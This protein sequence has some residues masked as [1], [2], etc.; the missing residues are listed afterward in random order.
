MTCK[1]NSCR[2]TLIAKPPELGCA[3]ETEGGEGLW[4][5]SVDSAAAKNPSKP[6]AEQDG[7]VFR[8]PCTSLRSSGQTGTCLS[9]RQELHGRWHI[10]VTSRT[11]TR[12]FKPLHTFLVLW[13]F[14]CIASFHPIAWLRTSNFWHHP[15]ASQNRESPLPR[16]PSMSLPRA[17]SLGLRYPPLPAPT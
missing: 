6:S 3:P 2:H 10:C 9:S 13:H 7:I 11:S 17:L 14:S 8:I 12:T 4:G 15:A 16:V 1:P 5:F